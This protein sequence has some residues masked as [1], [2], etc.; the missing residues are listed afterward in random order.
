MGLLTPA[1]LWAA[2]KLRLRIML[3]SVDSGDW[4]LRSAA[5]ARQKGREIGE[6]LVARPRLSEIILCHDDNVN[7]ISML[8]E[9]L[10]CLQRSG[11]DLSGSAETLWPA[12]A[13][14]NSVSPLPSPGSGRL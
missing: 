6:N 12:A 10:P 4:K 14:R 13:Y 5:V 2:S 11:C 3:W 1:T 7:T 9:I 8:E